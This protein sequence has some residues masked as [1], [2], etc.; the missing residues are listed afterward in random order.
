MNSILQTSFKRTA[1]TSQK[2]VV[3]YKYE[4][5][6]FF[7]YLNLFGTSQF[8]FWMYLSNFATTLRDV[9]A[10][11]TDDKRWY[12]RLSFLG[13]NKYRNGM[14][15]LFFFIG[16]VSVQFGILF[17]ETLLIDSFSFRSRNAESWR[18]IL[19]EMCS[20][21]HSAQRREDC[22]DCDLQPSARQEHRPG[23]AHHSHFDEGESSNDV[24]LH[25]HE[26]QG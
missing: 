3:L 10:Q 19:P 26:D 9:P 6:R 7:R 20:L 13:D 15:V 12:E 1:T 4:N 23:D 11:T 24:P 18:G 8:V 16:R 17:P 21:P 5:T 22:V 25:T 14:A 2:D